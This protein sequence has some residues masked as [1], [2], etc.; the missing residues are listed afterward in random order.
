MK[1]LFAGGFIM[2]S[3]LTSQ[4]LAQRGAMMRG[5]AGAHSGGMVVPPVRNPVPPL[6]RNPGMRGDHFLGRK[7][8]FRGNNGFNTPFSNWGWGGGYSSF[9]DP[10]YADD[11]GYYG[12]G[13]GYQPQASPSVVVVMPQMPLPLMPPPPALPIRPEIREYN[14]PDSGNASTAATFTI[15]SKDRKIDSAIAVWVQKNI[16]FYITP[17][18]RDGWIPLASIDREATRQQNAKKQ[19]TTPWLPAGS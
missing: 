10:F 12:D 1:G 2:A 14:W 6:G 17:N 5:G 9:F 11:A 13:G 8:G 7:F 19:L 15:V 4:L 16:V 3:L 18:G